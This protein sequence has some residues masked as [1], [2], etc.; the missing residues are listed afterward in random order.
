LRRLWPRRWKRFAVDISNGS[1]LEFGMWAL[2][3]RN[4]QGAEAGAPTPDASRG[5]AIRQIE[6]CASSAQTSKPSTAWPLS[7]A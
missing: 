2:R 7:E 5:F 3:R 4:R 1:R 6:L